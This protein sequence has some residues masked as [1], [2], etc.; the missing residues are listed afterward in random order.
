M[1]DTLT[2]NRKGEI[3][4][5]SRTEFMCGAANLKGEAGVQSAP[6]SVKGARGGFR[7]EGDLHS[8]KDL[9][10][11]GQPNAFTCPPGACEAGHAA[12]LLR[13]LLDRGPAISVS[14][15]PPSQP[16]AMWSRL[17]VILVT[18]RN[19]FICARIRSTQVKPY[20]PHL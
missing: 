10:P 12:R 15:R 8:N 3:A 6:R 9:A 5:Q 2:R 17:H 20:F 18:L 13:S 4:P 7:E 11:E 19:N 1:W 14:G 16:H